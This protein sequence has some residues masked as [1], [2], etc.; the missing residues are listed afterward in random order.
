MRKDAF[1]KKPSAE[2]VALF[3]SVAP[4]D[5]PGVERRMMFG[6]PAC[7]VNGNMFMSLF[8]DRMALRLSE[9]DRAQLLEIDDA[10][11]FEPME[12]RAMK[13]YVELPGQ[14]LDSPDLLEIWEG[15][16]LS[17]AVALP[18]KAK[19]ARKTRKS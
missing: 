7:F 3:D 18:P 9:S 1:K 15:R 6:Y 4:T 2:L 13:E 12:G 10:V 16:S 19:K 8:Q 5:E 17:Y 14:V 11:I